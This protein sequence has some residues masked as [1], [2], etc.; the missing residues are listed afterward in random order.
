MRLIR[1]DFLT[2]AEAQRFFFV[3][4]APRRE[5]KD[6]WVFA[7]ATVDAFASVTTML[8]LNRVPFKIALN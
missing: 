7:Y 8:A 2:G 1:V 4:F 6:F 5:K 3:C